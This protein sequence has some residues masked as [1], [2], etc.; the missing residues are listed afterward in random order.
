MKA[1]ILYIISATLLVSCVTAKKD[2]VKARYDAAIEKCVKKLRKK[3]GSFKHMD[4]LE[5]AFNMAQAQD[6]NKIQ[7]LKKEG[8]PENWDQIFSLYSMINKRQ[9]LVKSSPS[10]PTGIKFTN[11]EDDMVKS[12]QNAAEYYYSHASLLLKNNSRFDARKAYEEFQKVKSYYAN[13]KDTDQLLKTA[14]FQGTSFVQFKMENKSNMIIPAAFEQELLKMTLS[15]IDDEWL[16]FH[17]TARNDVDYNYLIHFRMMSLD[18]SP[19]QMKETQY[20]DKM[21]IEDGWDYVLDSKG[22]VMKDS[23]GNDLK[24]KKY[25]EI[26]ATITEVRQFKTAR[27]GGFL[28]FKNLESNQLMKSD[29][30]TSDAVFEHFSAIAAGDLRALSAESKKKIQNKPVPFPSTPDLIMMGA[31]NVKSMIT[32]IIYN[33]KALIQ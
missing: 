23:L 25:K 19:E 3:P 14:K 5:Q 1:I 18:I 27:I 13:Y 11:V 21:K 29:P 26:S 31:A 15:Q 6:L 20:I 10:I 4:I 2:L 32:N 8:T 30:V 7:L 33:H 12:K 24:V 22:N 9:S 28:D 16:E 17:T